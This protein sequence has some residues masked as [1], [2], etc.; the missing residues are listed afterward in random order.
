VPAVS[1]VADIEAAAAADEERLWVV[2]QRRGDLGNVDLAQEQAGD[3]G[4]PSGVHPSLDRDDGIRPQGPRDIVQVRDR[5]HLVEQGRIV[6]VDAGQRVTRRRCCRRYLLGRGRGP[7]VI[8]PARGSP[9]PFPGDRLPAQLPEE[10]DRPDPT[11]VRHLPRG[12]VVHQCLIAEAL[13][14]RPHLL[15]DQAEVLVHQAHPG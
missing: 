7:P 5:V 10:A 12:Q 13:E 15:P 6:G 4:P 9:G 11:L 8:R 2:P 1:A 14:E 3:R